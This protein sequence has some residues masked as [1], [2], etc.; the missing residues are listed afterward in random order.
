MKKLP[1]SLQYFLNYSSVLCI[2]G[3]FL[4][5][6]NCSISQIGGGETE[7]EA[8]VIVYMPDGLN[9]AAG[10]RVTIRSADDDAVF[11]ETETDDAGEF[12]V[13]QTQ[14]SQKFR[15]FFQKSDSGG[16]TLVAFQN[17]VFIDG[18]RHSIVD[19]TLQGSCIIKGVVAFPEIHNNRINRSKVKIHL[20]GTNKY[21]MADTA[22]MFSFYGV[23]N[24]SYYD[25]LVSPQEIPGYFDQY[26]NG[27]VFPYNLQ[28]LVL[29]TIKLQLKAIPP[30]EIESL[31]YDSLSG[32]VKITWRRSPIE[33]VS[34]YHI[35][36][37]PVGVISGEQ[38]SI[39]AGSITDDTSFV[40]V[41][42]SESEN[43]YQHSLY[44]TS[45]H[46]YRYLVEVEDNSGNFSVKYYSPKDT[47][48]VRS[49]LRFCTTVSSSLFDSTTWSPILSATKG[50]TAAVIC[51]LT[52]RR[53]PVISWCYKDGNDSLLRTVHLSRPSDFIIDTLFFKDTVSGI[54]PVRIEILDSTGQKRPFDTHSVPIEVSDVN[55]SLSNLTT[56]PSI[57][58]AGNSFS[59]EAEVFSEATGIVREN[60]V[61]ISYYFDS[62]YLGSKSMKIQPGNR[63]LCQFSVDD[64]TSLRTVVAGNHTVTASVKLTDSI[65]ELN[66]ADNM[67]IKNFFATDIDLQL[68]NISHDPLHIFDG[69]RVVFSATIFNNGTTDYIPLEYAK[70]IFNVDDAYYSWYIL[71]P[72]DTIKA[73][74]SIVVKGINNGNNLMWTAFPGKH[75]LTVM[76]DSA[77]VISELDKENN[78]IRTIFSVDTFN[79]YVEDFRAAIS[80]SLADLSYSAVIRRNGSFNTEHPNSSVENLP[81]T[82]LVGD[83]VDTAVYISFK[84][85]MEKDSVHVKVTQPINLCSCERTDLLCKIKINSQK[86][87]L[88]KEYSDNELSYLIKKEEV[89]LNGEM[90]EWDGD[91]IYG[92]RPV[93]ENSVIYRWDEPG[94]RISTS[95]T[96]SI[97]NQ[98]KTYG[99]WIFPVNVR[100]GKYYIISYLAKGYNIEHDSKDWPPVSVGFNSTGFLV[101]LEQTGT[102]GWTSK[103]GIL[104]VPE[105]TDHTNRLYIALNLGFLALGVNHGA[106]GI[107]HFDNV[108]MESY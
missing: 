68:I 19:D 83:T 108:K 37:L 44:D 48:T 14:N 65:S 24:N 64:S 13:P 45:V 17:S 90:D 6:L 91:S 72:T 18:H 76:L 4:F 100:R 96:I 31:I 84:E 92:W 27:I 11:Y 82:F 8:K 28:V 40:D 47:V 30:V 53:C 58:Y 23:P 66:T 29:D 43:S 55:I 88:E 38:R 12:E 103:C 69:N 75:N 5:F 95:R 15:V 32:R 77:N 39:A 102:F 2:T 56:V 62:L 106:K 89:D 59:I 25:L 51:A 46:R 35:S 49:P 16:D 22:G 81:V 101:P 9:R 71:S 10:A 42:F 1:L 54:K 94:E 104:R 79:I 74:K 93:A 21:T 63:I 70:V 80:D 7:N 97:N 26:V 87:I 105:L 61:E 34:Y 98:I 60:R 33:N 67:L 50:K 107:V 99:R 52:N 57:L 3:L 86:E 73:K 85:L 78:R 41:L 20:L 36:R